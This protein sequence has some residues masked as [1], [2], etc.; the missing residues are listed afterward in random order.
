M[1]IVTH[2]KKWTYTVNVQS[3]TKEDKKKKKPTT[4]KDKCFFQITV[5]YTHS[6]H[7]IIWC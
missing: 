1:H 6:I 5:E 3:K 7:Y 4:A 2:V